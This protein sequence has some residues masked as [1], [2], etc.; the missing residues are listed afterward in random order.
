MKKLKMAILI[1]FMMLALLFLGGCD[2]NKQ[3]F[4]TT[5]SYDKAITYIGR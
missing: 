3:I 1:G 5:Y 2:Y 4:D